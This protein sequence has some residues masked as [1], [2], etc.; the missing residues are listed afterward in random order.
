MI[1]IDISQKKNKNGKYVYIK[2]FNIIKHNI[3]TN[4][5]CNEIIALK[6]YNKT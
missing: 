4:G 5:I 2:V 3:N 6:S 1:L